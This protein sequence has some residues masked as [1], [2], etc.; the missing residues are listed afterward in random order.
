MK[1]CVGS[2]KCDRKFFKDKDIF[3]GFEVHESTWTLT[4]ICE[5][6]IIYD[7]TIAVDFERLGNIL[8]R[9]SQGEVHTVYQ[10]GYFGVWLHVSQRISQQGSSSHPRTEGTSRPGGDE[11][12]DRETAQESAESN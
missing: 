1:G 12:P 4:A 8:A 3:G 7:G 11:E 5:G 6:E 9:F 10:A 2:I